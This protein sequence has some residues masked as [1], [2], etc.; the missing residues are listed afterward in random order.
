MNYQKYEKDGKVA[1]LVSPGHGAGWST[2]ADYEDMEA[3]C[4]DADL[5]QC[6]L[7]KDLQKLSRVTEEKYPNTYMGGARSLVIEWVD[8]GEAFEITEYDGS[9]KLVI[10]SKH[11][12]MI[13]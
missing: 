9:E 12:Y 13:A 8:K 3:L 4:M 10:V 6:V 5:V 11:S 2:W 1:V 7:D